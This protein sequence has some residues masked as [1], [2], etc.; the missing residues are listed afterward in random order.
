MVDLWTEYVRPSSG[1]QL[2][3]ISQHGIDTAQ[4]VF[5]FSAA[6]LHNQPEHIQK[7]FSKLPG[8]GENPKIR[9]NSFH[10]FFKQSVIVPHSGH[11]LKINGGKLN[12][13]L[14][15]GFEADSEEKIG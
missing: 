4:N 15:V 7:F 5:L 6:G 2:Y 8:A 1:S 14:L 3:A 12:F 13:S 9:R 11:F 10:Y